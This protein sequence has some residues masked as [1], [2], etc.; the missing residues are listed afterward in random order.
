MNRR[1]F[2][3]DCIATTGAL[4]QEK[5]LCGESDSALVPSPNFNDSLEGSP[6]NLA[7]FGELQSWLSPEATPLLK[8]RMAAFAAG[9]LKL[10][11]FPWKDSEF[12]LG[13][14]W[15][16]FRTVDRVVIQFTREDRSPERGKQFV[17]FWNGLT[18]R[19]GN[20]RTLEDG[21]LLGV[22]LQIDGRTWTFNF[23]KRRTCKVRLR[24]QDQKQVEI[25][26]FQVFG[27]SRWKSG[28]VYIE[29]GHLDQERSYDGSLSL[30]NGEALEVR[31][32]GG[33]QALGVYAWTSAAGKGRTA[34]IIAKVLYTWGMDVDRTIATVRTKAFDFSFLPGEAL[35]D[36]PIDLPEYGIYI[37]NNALSL[38]RETYQKRNA[39]KSRIIDAVR[40]HPEQ[41][42][43]NAYQAIRA[44][45]VP[46]SFVG[47]DSNS[48]K[49]GVAP[50]G[51]WVIGN[52]DPSYGQQILP[53]YAIYFASTEETTLFQQPTYDPKNLFVGEEEKSQELEEGWLP[54][55][56]TK[57]SRNDVRFE[58]LDYAAL[59][60]APEP[61]DE[62][63][64]MG[65]ELAFMISRLTIRNDSGLPKTVHYYLR[66]WK[67]V[68]G[69]M[70]YGAI[71]ADVENAGGL[72]EMRIAWL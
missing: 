13:V 21:T 24:L 44:K 38:D 49:F 43:A 46:L 72:R 18:S 6:C 70:P 65:N 42:L 30:Y 33:A 64:L 52:N 14:E 55:V 12:D 54:I 56:V 2:L 22:P 50:D 51:H 58:R 53:K 16:E 3:N 7:L 69:E 62:S 45:R 29:W 71:P 59:D 26:S 9:A 41:T 17:E 61:V 10:Q 23:P 8:K 63:H 67:P 5:C 34:G 1:K 68:T 32:F 48:Q 47:V 31:T 15:P 25:E 57:W 27:P 4:W 20:W 66:P 35:E 39:N 19:Q 60:H 11:E 40:N 28:E 37:R 36:Q